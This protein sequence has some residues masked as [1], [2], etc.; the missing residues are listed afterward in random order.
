MPYLHTCSTVLLCTPAIELEVP[1]GAR[2]CPILTDMT[3]DCAELAS[4]LK[5]TSNT[6]YQHNSCHRPRLHCSPPLLSRCRA[7]RLWECN[8]P[9]QPLGAASSA[10]ESHPS[11]HWIRSMCNSGLEARRYVSR[12]SV[13]RF[14][15]RAGYAVPRRSW[16]PE[17]TYWNRSLSGPRV[18]DLHRQLY[19]TRRRKQLYSLNSLG[20]ARESARCAQLRHLLPTV[21]PLAV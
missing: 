10:I 21:D 3:T 12:Y 8:A 9:W 1:G 19:L 6:T 4:G 7:I 5:L 16:S 14:L 15:L 13:Q 2:Q 17:H 11:P 18:N 20:A